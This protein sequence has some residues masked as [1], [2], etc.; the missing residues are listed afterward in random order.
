MSFG[1]QINFNIRNKSSLE[2]ESKLEIF[3]KASLWCRYEWPQIYFRKID[4][5]IQ[6]I[7][8]QEISAAFYHYYMKHEKNRMAALKDTVGLPCAAFQSKRAFPLHLI[9]SLAEVNTSQDH[10]TALVNRCMFPFTLIKS[11]NIS[12]HFFIF[13]CLPYKTNREAHENSLQLKKLKSDN[14]IEI[15]TSYLN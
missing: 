10:S 9:S 8:D 1:K 7:R 6:E 5:W 12:R 11:R 15:N 3:L 2:L 4:K 13:F 14:G